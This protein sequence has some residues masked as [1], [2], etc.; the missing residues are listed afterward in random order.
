[1][2]GA[3][4]GRQDRV[5]VLIPCY[6]EAATIEAV[7]HDFLQVLPQATIYVY[8]NASTDDTADRARRAGAVVRSES[9]RGK[10]NVVR[11]MFADVEADV[12]VMV[13]G[14]DTYDAASAAKLISR[15]S[16]EHLDMVV[17]C[18]VSSAQE[19]YRAG[20]RFGNRMLTRCVSLIFGDRFTDMLSGYRA[21]SRRFVKSFPALSLGFEIETELT[22]HAL[23]LNVPIAEVSTPYGARPIGSSSKLS[24]YRDGFRILMT[25]LNLFKNERP[26]AFF[27][28]LAA[29]L[30]LA[31]VSLSVPVLLTYLQTGLVPRLPTALLST[32]IMLLAFLS[33]ACGL[34]LDT[35]TQGR[36]ELR[37]LAYLQQ[38]GGKDDAGSNGPSRAD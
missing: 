7:V 38:A 19:A 4:T 2:T 9:L 14:D 12:Y 20:H 24:T 32:G 5:A 31:S 34:I 37:R 29:L 28:S 27:A 13:D 22:I 11:R 17:G 35:V 6:N 26:L 30:A 10:G 3:G 1:M 25:I 23:T 36:R 21:F 33:V 15:L 8:E 18:R 16:N